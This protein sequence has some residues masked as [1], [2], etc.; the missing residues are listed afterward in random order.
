MT[1]QQYKAAIE[2]A[3]SKIGVPA[4]VEDIFVVPD[5]MS[6]IGPYIDS[7]FGLA[8]KKTHTQLQ[9]TFEATT[10]IQNFPNGVKVGRGRILAKAF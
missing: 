6:W 1:P 8:F 7:K 5:Y 3:L 9:F 10:D 4:V 2:G